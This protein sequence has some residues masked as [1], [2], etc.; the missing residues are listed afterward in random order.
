[1][2]TQLAQM[3]NHKEPLRPKPNPMRENLSFVTGLNLWTRFRNHMVRRQAPSAIKPDMLGRNG[4]Q[5]PKGILLH[6]ISST[7]MEEHFSLDA[8]A[9]TP[10]IFRHR[11]F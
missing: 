3:G 5:I 2:S 9:Q 1:M 11:G 4:C 6:P 8:A 10:A 7:E